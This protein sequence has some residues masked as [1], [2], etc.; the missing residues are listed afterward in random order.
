MNMRRVVITGMG[1]WSC[2]GTSLDEVTNSLRQ[3]KNGIVSIPTRSEY[4]LHCPLVG[5]IP[6]P[7]LKPLLHDR[8]A[9]Q[10]MSEE[11]EYAYMAAHQAFLQAGITDDFLLQNEVGILF[12]NDTSVRAVIDIH[13][14]MELY[15]DTASIPSGMLFRAES[16]SPTISLSSIFHLRGINASIG[17]ACASSAHA[18][19]LATLLI[20]HGLQDMVL[21][22]G[23]QEVNQW[24]APAFEAIGAFSQDTNPDTACRPFDKH[25]SGLVPS[26][27]AAALILEEYEHAVARGANI[28]AEV[29]GYGFSSN[30][31]GMSEPSREGEK[32]S[33]ERALRDANLQPLDIDYINAHATSTVAGDIEEAIAVTKLFG[34]KQ[35]LISSTKSMTGHE[36]WMAGAS[37]VLYS[38]LMMQNGFVAPNIHLDEVD[39]SAAKLRLV[40]ETTEVRLKT[41]MSN[42]FGFGG[43]NSTL[44]IRKI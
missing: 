23:C 37:E 8:R 27:G 15:H 21:V 12:G 11:T 30:G 2:L 39:E 20:R 9:R 36:C 7:D 13:E 29:I 1:I 24:E 17:A 34:D 3:G 31:I 19:G 28:L 43:T 4:G 14:L 25:R 41:I 22:G 40:S 33:M 10:S 44:I 6:K 5:N 35:P 38:I 42:S 16:S 18:I 26:G 32:R